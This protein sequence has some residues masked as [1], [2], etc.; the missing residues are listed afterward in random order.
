MN[1]AVF[2][3]PTSLKAQPVRELV[4][5]WHRSS[6]P[7][8]FAPLPARESTLAALRPIARGAFTT[9]GGARRGS[10]GQTLTIDKRPAPQLLTEIDLVGNLIVPWAGRGTSLPGSDLKGH[11][12]LRR[13][14]LNRRRQDLPSDPVVAAQ[15][16]DEGGEP[17]G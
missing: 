4:A 12:D 8:Q 16:R 11:D 15:P 13:T 9:E 17:R 14:Y 3:Q 1:G 2:R 7:G 6:R 10:T 5:A